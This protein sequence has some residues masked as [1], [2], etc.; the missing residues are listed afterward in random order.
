[1][2]RG[3]AGKSTLATRLGAITGIPVV[4]LDEH[5]WQP[6]ALS[7]ER[8]AAVQRDLVAAPTWIMDGDL[9]PYDSA[10][11][12]RLAAA[13]TVLLLDFSLVRCGWRALRRSRENAEFWRWLVSYRRRWRPLVRRAIA[14]HASGAEVYVLRTPR[15]V[16]RFEKRLG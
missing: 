14:Q 16:A 15:A 8:W 3:G 5:F 12:V 2:G 11:E 6:D 10:V 7:P 9:G 1:M 13:D 4:E